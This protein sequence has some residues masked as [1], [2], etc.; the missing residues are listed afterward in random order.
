MCTFQYGAVGDV[1]VYVDPFPLP[2]NPAILG[3]GHDPSSAPVGNYAHSQ[4]VE[5]ASNGGAASSEG[6]STGGSCSGSNCLTILSVRTGTRCN[7]PQS[8]EVDIR[9]DSNQYL[10][11]YIVF[12]APGKKIY[13]A[14]DIMAPGQIERGTQFTCNATPTV[15][16]IANVG[17]RNSV[18]YPSKSE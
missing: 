2:T 7:S 10:R 8:V 15:G 14:T 18:K 6:G 5:K 16:R 13:A 4:V 9:N 12:D 17:D 1:I 3:S 11:G